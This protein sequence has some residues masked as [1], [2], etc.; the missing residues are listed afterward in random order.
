MGKQLANLGVLGVELCPGVFRAEIY[1]LSVSVM[2]VQY[3]A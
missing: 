3:I 2:K 1:H